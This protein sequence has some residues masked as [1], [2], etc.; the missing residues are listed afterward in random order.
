MD[1]H[2]GARRRDAL[3][4]AVQRADL[5]QMLAIR[6]ARR[7]PRIFIGGY[8]ARGDHVVVDQEGDGLDRIR[9]V[10]RESRAQG[11]RSGEDAPI[12]LARASDGAR[13]VSRREDRGALA[14][15]LACLRESLSIRQARGPAPAGSRRLSAW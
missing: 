4:A 11:L 15:L 3:P 7:V 9:L 6:H 13:T 10:R 12:L 5:H 1:H 2:Q 8:I 14:D